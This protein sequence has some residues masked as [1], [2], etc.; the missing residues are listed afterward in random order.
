MRRDVPAPNRIVASC[1]QEYF[2]AP[3]CPASLI[4]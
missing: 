2:S 1:G 4:R 3:R